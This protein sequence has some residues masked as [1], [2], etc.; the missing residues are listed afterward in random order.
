MKLQSAE[1]FA[2]EQDE[3]DKAE[4]LLK[5]MLEKLEISKNLTENA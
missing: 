1:A 3:F 2:R 4:N 5:E